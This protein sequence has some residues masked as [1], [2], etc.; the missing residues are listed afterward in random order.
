[1]SWTWSILG[2]F[3]LFACKGGAAP[4]DMDRSVTLV[5]DS[6]GYVGG[7]PGN[8]PVSA[9]ILIGTGKSLNDY[10]KCEWSAAD[11]A[12]ASS[13]RR[14]EF[15]CRGPRPVVFAWEV[16]TSSGAV[17]PLNECAKDIP[18]CLESKTRG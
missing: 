5:Q 17:T 8:E 6:R 1:M 14:V 4:S 7:K 3:V 9:L 10:D 15:T 13:R 2:A 11:S 18:R 12:G 16:D